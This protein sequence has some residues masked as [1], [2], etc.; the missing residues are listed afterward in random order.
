MKYA[1]IYDGCCNLC[2]TLVQALEQLERGKLFC[3][4]PMQDRE[5]LAQWQITTEDCERG[6]IVLNLEQPQERWQGSDAAEQI[7]QLLPA[8]QALIQAYRA[9]PGL[10]AFGDRTYTQVR[11]HRYD[12]FGRRAKV[13]Q[14]RYPF[15]ERPC[16]DCTIN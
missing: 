4:V 5:R 9:I 6:M 10:K 14:P 8:G 15:T 13:Y 1:V 2:T 7:T 3:Y 11:D 12:W 16:T